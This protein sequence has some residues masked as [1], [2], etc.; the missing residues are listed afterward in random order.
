MAARTSRQKSALAAL[1][2]TEKATVFDELLAIRPDL[3]ELAETHAARLIS[4]EDRSAVAGDA[5]RS[6]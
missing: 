3:R 1:T 6:R 5:T 4:N 2:A